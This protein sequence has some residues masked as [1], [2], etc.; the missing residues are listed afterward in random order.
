[1]LQSHLEGRR[2]KSQEAEKERE[3]VG[4]LGGRWEGEE[5]NEHIQVWEVRR[6]ALRASSPP[7][8][9]CPELRRNSGQTWAILPTPPS[10][11]PISFHVFGSKFSF[12]LSL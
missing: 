3:R 5:K 4:D 7:K 1:M 2:K 11:L 9:A 6:E 10:P 12:L 8:S